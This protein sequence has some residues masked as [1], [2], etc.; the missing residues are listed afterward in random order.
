[1]R[2]LSSLIAACVLIFSGMVAGQRADAEEDGGFYE[3]LMKAFYST[4]ADDTAPGETPGD[5]ADSDDSC[6]ADTDC[7]TPDDF[8]SPPGCPEEPEDDMHS[9]G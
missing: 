4:Q 6:P 7:F 3:E 2:H 8:Y 1:M 5:S 9:C